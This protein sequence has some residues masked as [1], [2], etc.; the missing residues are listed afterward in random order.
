MKHYTVFN[1][2]ERGLYKQ[3]HAL[4]NWSP[5]FFAIGV[6]VYFFL[7]YEIL[8]W[9]IGGAVCLA[10]GGAWW[11][12]GSPLG[13]RVALAVLLCALGCAD[14]V[15]EARRKPEMPALP[16]RAVTVTGVVKSVEF[17]APRD[18]G[19]QAGLEGAARRLHV[20][21]AIF[22]TPSDVGML[23]LRR[24]LT[25]RLRADD[26]TE[27]LSGQKVSV[28]AILR[29][30]QRP[31][32]PGGRDMQREAW[33]SGSAGSGYALGYA[34]KE[35]RPEGAWLN[36]IREGIAHR[37]YGALP[38]Q[39]GAIAATVM[40]GESSQ[41]TQQ[42]REEF[43][44]SGLAHLLA[45]AGLHLGLVMAGVMTFIRVMMPLSERAALYWPC[46]EIAV[47]GGF[48]FGAFYV[49]ITG[50]HL[51][52]VRALGMAGL[53]VV[54]LLCGRKVM[55]MRSLAVIAMCILV[56]TP[57]AVLDVSFQM[58]FAAVMGLIA[59]Y[60][61]LRAPLLALRGEGQLWRSVLV[62]LVMLA[63]TSVFA[64]LAT[65]P[66][67]MAHFGAF[68]PWFVFANMVAV[69]LMAV[70]VMPLGIISVLLMPLHLSHLPQR[71]MGLG[72]ECIQWLAEHVAQW[73]Y[74]HVPV[75]AMPS[76]GLC[77]VMLGLSVLCLWRGV[78]R[79]AGIV[80]II[81]GLLSVNVMRPLMLVA[82]DAGV[83]AIRSGAVLQVGPVGG[84]D[85]FVLEQWQQ[86]LA[87]R[88]V[89]M[90]TACQEGLCRISLEGQVF[91]LRTKDRTD[92]YTAPS[93]ELCKDVTLFVSVSPA[94]GACPGS[95]QIDRF[96]VWRD[97]AFAVYPARGGSVRLVSARMAQGDRL[98]VPPVGWRGVPTLPLANAE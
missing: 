15:W 69:P 23:P 29:Q 88:A 84:L 41:L 44:V 64:G 40:A 22:D 55:S 66:V 81:L 78:A 77:G 11:L 31:A 79:W 74:A 63:A 6:I 58:S 80:P 71:G 35:G 7:P 34:Q 92:G 32:W 61:A 73:P 45:V 65:L 95:V 18:D 82:P 13:G 9:E 10:F 28:R 8:P 59:G 26:A 39:A 93:S 57:S 37:F 3:G 1:W 20:V 67:S 83:M 85:R 54:A 68:Q 19:V 72:I 91:L 27:V 30:P 24:E 70:W 89:P 16:M 56:V 42:T 90:P 2:I 17:L 52:S 51:P 75:P 94:R 60:E 97:G 5:V 14:A 50:A 86:A 12:R 96:A 36:R 46:K 33:F 87:L 38:G 48:L 25:I 53:F 98:W 47:L 62:H 21:G 76:W 4:L 43:S 49:L